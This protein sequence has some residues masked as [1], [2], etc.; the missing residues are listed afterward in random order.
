MPFAKAVIFDFDGTIADSLEETA[1]VYNKVA[2]ELG[3]SLLHKSDYATIRQMNP[4]EVMKYAGVPLR[5]MP[6]LMAAVRAGML[7]RMEFVRPFDGVPEAIRVLRAQGC[8][9][10]ILSSNS[11]ENIKRFLQRHDLNAFDLFSCGTSLFGKATRLRRLVKQIG[12]PVTDIYYVGDE[13][14]DVA[15]ANE[16]GVRSI[17]VSWG[18]SFRDALR[19][20]GPTHIADRAEQLIDFVGLQRVGTAALAR[21]VVAHST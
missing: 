16:V 1:A 19:E 11:L 9:C 2:A 13:V 4:L 6:R 14:R 5:K 10:G 12:L 7:E 21:S 15:A 8:R 20:V 18:F 3:V 17:A